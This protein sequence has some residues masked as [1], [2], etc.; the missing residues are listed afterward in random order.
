LRNKEKNCREGICPAP[1]SLSRPTWDDAQNPK[2]RRE[3]RR[4][5][6]ERK[7]GRQRT[8][9]VPGTLLEKKKLRT[10]EGRRGVLSGE[11]SGTPR[12]VPFRGGEQ[13]E[14]GRG[15]EKLRIPPPAGGRR[16][17]KRKLGKKSQGKGGGKR[18]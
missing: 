1:L 17:L 6:S 4:R 16:N 5:K 12:I 8:E 11:I 18:F 7:E 2:D 9:T 13:R 3:P 14:A 10:R 15:R